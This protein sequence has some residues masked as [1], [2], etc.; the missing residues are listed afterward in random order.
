MDDPLTPVADIDVAMT[1]TSRSQHVVME[2]DLGC[3]DLHGEEDVFIQHPGLEKH[4]HDI[5][6]K[7][8]TMAPDPLKE[9]D[10]L[11][12]SSASPRRA[13]PREGSTGKIDSPTS[14]C[15]EQ[16]KLKQPPVGRLQK[17]TTLSPTE[18]KLIVRNFS[19]EEVQRSLSNPCAAEHELFSEK[20]DA[21]DENDTESS[22]ANRPPGLMTLKEREARRPRF[23]NILRPLRRSH[24]AGCSQDAPA[25]AL[26][27]RHEL[28]REKKRT[29]VGVCANVTNY[30]F[31]ECFCSV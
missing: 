22:I 9:F 10:K 17:H 12:L 19:I 27:L 28:D 31:V 1:L 26:F 29:L 13:V 4:S 16:F 20:I 25:Y 7:K 5:S 6:H 24:S 23:R 15:G 2:Q 11:L 14:P 8:Q 30:C 3:A 21:I 18:R